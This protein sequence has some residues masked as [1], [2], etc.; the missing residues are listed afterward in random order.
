VH[1]DNH[2]ITVDPTHIESVANIAGATAFLAKRF[3][4]PVEEGQ[5]E[6]VALAVKVMFPE[7]RRWLYY[8]SSFKENGSIVPFKENVKQHQTIKR[9]QRNVNYKAKMCCFSFDEPHVSNNDIFRYQAQSDF[10]IL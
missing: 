6:F 8:C 5:K 4:I 10:T 9:R 1:E 7:N 2:P 3:V